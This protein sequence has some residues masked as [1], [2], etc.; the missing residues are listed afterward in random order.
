MPTKYYSGIAASYV[1]INDVMFVWAWSF[2]DKNNDRE[3]FD[4]DYRNSRNVPPQAFIG[5]GALSMERKQ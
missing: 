1:I 5:A 4:Y 3:V 2:Y